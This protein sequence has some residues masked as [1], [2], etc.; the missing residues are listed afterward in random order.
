MRYIT[1]EDLDDLARGAAV[2]GTGGG[3]D[4]YI[5]KLIAA[6]AIRAHGPVRVVGL[7]D[8]APCDLIVPVAVIGAPTVLLEKAPSG[9]EAEQVLGA[10]QEVL[11]SPVRYVACLEAGGL[12]SMI[13]LAVAARTGLPLID[14][15]GMGRAFPEIQM[16]LTTL[17]GVAATPM[18]L[19]DAHG[20]A[21][22]LRT[23]DNRWAERLARVTTV[24]MGGAAFMALYPMR[25]EQAAASLVPA[26]LSWALELGRAIRDARAAHRD[27][28]RAAAAVLRGHVLFTGKVE[29]VARRTEG[30]FVRGEAC[31]QGLDADTGHGMVLRFQNEHLIALRDGVPVVTVP[32]LICVLD[33]ET[34]TPV[35]TESMRYGARVSVIGAPCD[36]RW[37]TPEGLDLTGPRY[38]GYDLDYRPVEELAGVPSPV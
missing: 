29:D 34:G 36:P 38:F 28:A 10:L 11:G 33:A 12:N 23:V 26:T 2:L 14:A 20:N 17:A 8:I 24:E 30:G 19:A 16:V 25:G 32:D 3:G 22:V 15:D 18:A 1:A 7:D 27:P 21:S 13:P 4:P 31:L 9:A 5:G 35:T 37:R 6:E